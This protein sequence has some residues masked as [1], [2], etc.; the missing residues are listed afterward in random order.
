MFKTT[1]PSQRPA[2]TFG[3][4]GGD[5]LRRGDELAHDPLP[6]KY[7]RS[8]DARSEIRPANSQR[9]RAAPTRGDRLSER[10]QRRPG[11]VAT[12]GVEPLD[13]E[14]RLATRDQVCIYGLTPRQR[15]VLQEVM[16]GYSEKEIAS[17]LAITVPTV[18]EH[19][20]RV[21]RHFRAALLAYLLRRTPAGTRRNRR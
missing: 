19:L 5:I 21:Y 4:R 3:P 13:D 1:D 18:N 15:E 10:R 20:Q 17:A 7:E 6:G 2:F 8:F 14:G 12:R 16:R 11:R 9:E